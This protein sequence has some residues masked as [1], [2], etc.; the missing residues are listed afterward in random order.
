MK[1]L[2]KI[3][4]AL[5]GLVSMSSISYAMDFG[6]R[7][8]LYQR[9]HLN[10][11]AL[12]KRQIGKDIVCGSVFCGAS[13]AQSYTCPLALF[14]VP[15]CAI[16]AGDNTFVVNRCITDIAMPLY[17]TTAALCCIQCVTANTLMKKKNQ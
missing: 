12:D 1:N 6:V 16:A 17:T 9:Y 3:L 11:G 5:F 13:Y 4:F 2:T 15:A 8:Q 7:A 10:N 14:S